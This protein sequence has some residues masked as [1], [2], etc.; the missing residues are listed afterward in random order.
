MEGEP[1]FFFF[2][3]SF[4]QLKQFII[5]N[6]LVIIPFY[7]SPLINIVRC[8]PDPFYDFVLQFMGAKDGMKTFRGRKQ[9]SKQE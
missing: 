5:R 3:F 1:P 9:P 8:V 6:T 7:F 4:K 2:F